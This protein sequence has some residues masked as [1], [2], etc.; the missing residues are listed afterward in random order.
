M[1]GCK[2]SNTHCIPETRGKSI[3]MSCFIAM[4]HADCW[5]TRRSHTG[6]I[7]FINRAPIMWYSKRQNTMEL[8]TFGSELVAMK[9][10]IEMV[11]GLHYK[12]R[13]MGVGIE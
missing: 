5:V 9:K 2:G 6:V 13:M 1:S 12:L 7:T 11:E 3:V 8:S 10:A 4:D